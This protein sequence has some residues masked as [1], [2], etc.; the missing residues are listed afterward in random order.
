MNGMMKVAAYYGPADIRIEERPIPAIGDDEVLLKLTA[1]G[2]C[3]T[4]IHKA[5]HQTVPQGTVLGHEVSGTIVEA[6]KSVENFREGDRVFVAHHVPC[7]SCHYCQRGHHSL[8][9]QFSKTNI[10]PGGFSEYIRIPSLN[11]RHSMLKLP[12]DMSAEHAAL[13]EPAACCWRGLCKLDIR[14]GDSV[15]IVGAGQ[16]GMMFTQMLRHKL[17]GTI[18]VSDLS[19]FRLNAALGMGADAAIDAGTEDLVTRTRE[20]TGGKGV[21]YAI[22]TAGVPGILM[23][24]VQC[25]D[26]GG[27]VLEFVQFDKNKPELIPAERFFNDEIKLVG[28]YSSTSFDYEPMLHSIY[29]GIIDAEKMITHRM[30]LKDI[31]QA[32]ALVQDKNSNCLKVILGTQY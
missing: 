14:A 1:C 11:V 28:T 32:I 8:C 31:N 7:F 23:Q 29:R 12:D 9:R 13:I 6:G 25:L 19:H 2:L 20:L 16:T 30:N 3:G 26:R 4:D 10:D 22:I 21:D 15:L 17:V 24:A 18:I 27:T 5:V